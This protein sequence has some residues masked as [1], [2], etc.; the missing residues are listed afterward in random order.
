M[1]RVEIEIKPGVK[2]VIVTTEPI[3][4]TTHRWVILISNVIQIKTN[5]GTIYNKIYC[6]GCRRM[7]DSIDPDIDEVSKKEIYFG[8][9]PNHKFYI[10]TKDE[11]DLLLSMFK[12]KG[13]KY[14]KSINK[15]IDR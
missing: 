2:G 9:T 14:V 15:V 12:E 1:D 7:I 13:L 10:S 5:D 11:K 6:Y 8:D 3:K 4:Y